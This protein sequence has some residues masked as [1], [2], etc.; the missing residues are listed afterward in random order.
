MLQRRRSFSNAW[1]NRR[2]GF[3]EW[4]DRYFAFNVISAELDYRTT[5]NCRVEFAGDAE[6]SHAELIDKL[7][8]LL[9]KLGLDFAA[10]DF[11]TSPDDRSPVFLE[12]NTGPMFAA[13]DH[14]SNGK[15]CD[16]MIEHLTRHVSTKKRASR[17]LSG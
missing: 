16:A 10:A 17:S 15:L 11:K 4:V 12:V 9:A 14:A 7:G 1:H 2:S 5:Q 13:F 6:S 8:K 3:I